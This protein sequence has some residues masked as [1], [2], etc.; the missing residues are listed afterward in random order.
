VRS[1]G[2][3][4]FSEEGWFF[5]LPYNMSCC[6]MYLCSGGTKADGSNLGND[7]ANS[8][9]KVRWLPKVYI[10]EDLDSRPGVCVLC[11]RAAKAFCRM[12]ILFFAHTLEF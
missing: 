3:E 11:I 10:V 2:L 9:T 4:S 5:T 7:S 1:G 12:F 8:T 6:G